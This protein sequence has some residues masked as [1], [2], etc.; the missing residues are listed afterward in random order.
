V[1][2]YM[3]HLWILCVALILS[4]VVAPAAPAGDFDGSRP[5]LC[6][7]IKVIELTPAADGA[8]SAESVGLPQFLR[9]DVAKKKVWPAMDKEGKRVSEI[10]RVERLDGKLILQG[11]DAGIADKRDGTGWSAMISEATGKFTV[12]M[13]RENEAFVVFGA[14]L[15][16]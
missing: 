16:Q 2:A 4:V 13:A 5:M 7:V 1:E 15:P 10:K 11:A 14:C 6:S 8:V 9:V 3:K 12:T